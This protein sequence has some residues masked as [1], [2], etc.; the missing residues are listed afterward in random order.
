MKGRFAL[1]IFLTTFQTGCVETIIMDSQE[2]DRPVAVNCILQGENRAYEVWDYTPTPQTQ[3]M[4]I[5]YIKGQSEG[6]YIPV[7]DAEVS[8]SY[9]SGSSQQEEILLFSYA[10][11]GRWESDRPIVIEPETEYSLSIVIPGREPIWAKT[12]S[13]PRVYLNW[14]LQSVESMAESAEGMREY[15][16]HSFRFRSTRGQGDSPEGREGVKGYSVWIYPQEYVEGKW[17]DLDYIVTNNPYADDFNINNMKFS[18]LEVLGR[19]ADYYPHL[20]AATTPAEYY[21]ICFD[22]ARTF[23]PNLP[24]HEKFVRI[25]NLEADSFFFLRGGPIWFVEP[26]SWNPNVFR[27]LCHFV[28]KDL[29]EY[30]R[31]VYVHEYGLDHYLTTL[32]SNSNT[33]SNI[34]GGIGI[35]GCDSMSTLPLLTLGGAAN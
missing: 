15:F 10:G 17:I 22:G 5:R 6:E 8:L 24:V 25:D 19:P 31:Y 14:N 23:A 7:M 3:S 11:E 12:V 27:C 21:V 16:L 4:T 34:H 30:L 9:V 33:Y 32:Y 2:R 1:L 29:D 28:S 13:A 20:S 26:E 18:D 35:F